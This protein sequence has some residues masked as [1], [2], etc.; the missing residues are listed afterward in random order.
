MRTLSVNKRG[1]TMH[2]QGVIPAMSTAFRDDLSVDHD[3]VARHAAWMIDAGCTGIVAL[4]SPGEGATLTD[5]EKRSLLQ[6]SLNAVPQPAPA[7]AR[8][9]PPSTAQALPR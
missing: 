4:G 8:I 7:A 1:F 2:W 3:F 5:S 6:T 9:S